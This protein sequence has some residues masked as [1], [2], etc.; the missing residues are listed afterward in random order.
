MAAPTPP[1]D[2]QA[3]IPA[4]EQPSA[5]PSQPAAPNYPLTSDGM[6]RVTNISGS[7]YKIPAAKATEILA[8]DPEYRPMTPD[9]NKAFELRKSWSG[10]GGFATGL[11]LNLARGLT[12]PIPDLIGSAIGGQGYRDAAKA[13]D[14]VNPGAAVIGETLGMFTPAVA[15]K[16]AN[17][18][19]KGANI[20]AKGLGAVAK[21]AE[22]AAV[23][24]KASTAAGKVVGQVADKVLGTQATGIFARGAQAGA[25]GAAVVAAETLPYALSHQA[26]KA[27][28]DN[29]FHA[30]SFISGVGHE[31]MFGAALGGTLSGIGGMVGAA[32]KKLD[33][34]Y[35]NPSKAQGYRE[36]AY[37][38][39]FKATGGKS[40]EVNAMMGNRAIYDDAGNIK[41]PAGSAEAYRSDVNRIGEQVLDEITVNTKPR[42]IAFRAD[43]KKAEV[44]QKQMQAVESKVA[45]NTT[46]VEEAIQRLRNDIIVPAKEQAIT[47]EQK[48]G[49]RA[50]SSAINEIERKLVNLDDMWNGKSVTVDQATGTRYYIDADGMTVT[51]KPRNKLSD[52]KEQIQL[53]DN[54]IN[55]NGDISNKPAIQR[56]YMAIRDVMNQIYNEGVQKATTPEM[57]A[58]YLA[59]K[60]LYGTWKDIETMAVKQYKRDS[61][62]GDRS[63]SDYVQGGTGSTVLTHVGGMSGAAATDSPVGGAFGAAAG[64][65]FG[66]YLG[67]RVNRVWGERHLVWFAKAYEKLADY[68]AIM[69]Q[70]QRLGTKIDNG[71]SNFVRATAKNVGTP[72]RAAYNVSNKQYEEETKRIQAMKANPETIRVAVQSAIPA[73]V[74]SENPVFTMNAYNTVNRQV[75]FL[76]SKIPQTS[77]PMNALQPVLPNGKSPYPSVPSI[78]DKAKWNRY[79]AALTDPSVMI[80]QAAAGNL[81]RETVEAVRTVYPATYRRIVDAITTSVSKLDKPLTSQ[82]SAALSLIMQTPLTPMQQPD[83]IAIFQESF[84]PDFAS[85][86]DGGAYAPVI[87]QPDGASNRAP[88]GSKPARPIDVSG[89]Y[90]TTVQGMEGEIR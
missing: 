40:G 84:N 3:A 13:I 69:N 75:D 15:L 11:G 32:A 23:I 82:Q 59:G 5:P 25:R 48:Q 21:G 2:P 77:R 7:V 37:Q 9:E 86:G 64:G 24:P 87:G 74:Q 29:E 70:S 67:T 52:L 8:N 78:T 49:I 31:L 42:E 81:D 4:P 30:E 14:E 54:E 12:G 45:N 73:H 46:N 89:A 72:L 71:I 51:N 44:F 47:I 65:M 35:L 50:A 41:F 60:K 28:L 16:A 62:K 58:D 33:A 26:T 34:K 53:L 17:I 80:R 79:M 61:V 38:E 88:S 85:D 90:K 76:A 83:M 18:A 66:A 63:M 22:A 68:S 36:S 6:V 55:W 10:A 39:A 56:Q 57:Y 20:A 19:S 1:A 27:V 43:A